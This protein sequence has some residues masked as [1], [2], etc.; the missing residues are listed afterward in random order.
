MCFGPGRG[1]AHYNSV[2]TH[3]AGREQLAGDLSQVDHA[4]MRLRAS[5]APLSDVEVQLP[6]LLP[7]WT[8]GHC[9]THIAR[10]ADGIDNLVQWA[11]TDV[12]TSMYPSMESRD[13]DIGRGANR[14]ADVLRDDIASS[15]ER[16]AT[17]MGALADADSDALQRLVIFGAP[18]PSTPPNT[19]AHE[20]GFARWR[21]VTIHHADLGL[22]DFS[23]GDFDNTFVARTL[24]FIE[25]RSGT[26]SVTGPAVDVL[27]WRLGRGTPSSVLDEYG[28]PPGVP[29]AW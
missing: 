26:V 24:A 7:G 2:M 27:T 17:A 23:Y 6:S 15:A 29:P 12:R 20:L 19:P 18:P 5:I 8:I 25:A 10:N 28:N 1:G 13:A 21:E 22:A 3:D 4:T 16:L 9:L 11:L 14:S